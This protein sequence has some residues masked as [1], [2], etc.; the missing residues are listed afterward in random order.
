MEILICK[1]SSFWSNHYGFLYNLL[2]ILKFSFFQARWLVE[3]EMVPVRLLQERCEVGST[4]HLF[5][6]F[7]FV[8]SV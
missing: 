6:L 2:L 7:P 5:F 4:H 3:S 1:S 8:A